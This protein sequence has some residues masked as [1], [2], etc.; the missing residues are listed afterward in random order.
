MARKDFEDFIT[1][2]GS[3]EKIEDVRAGLVEMKDTILKDYDSYDQLN[4]D[5]EKYK[6]DNESLRENNMKLFLHVTGGKKPEDEPGAKP[7]KMK[8]EDL[9][10]EKGELK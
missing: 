4:T 6:K 5:N 9:F 3:M 1:K 8:Y 2:L 10:N 7:E